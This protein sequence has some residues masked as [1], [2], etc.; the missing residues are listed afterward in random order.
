M[1][2]SESFKK[3]IEAKLQMMAAADPL[4]ATS[5]Q[6]EGKTLDGCIN[7]ILTTVQKSGCAGFADDEIFGMAAHY[8]D[9]DKIEVGKPVNCNVVV[10]HVVELTE[11]EKAAAKKEAFERIISQERERIMKK[12]AP[13]PL[14]LAPAP[15]QQPTLF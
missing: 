1:K 7:Y 10:N 4:F 13:K 9:E 3:T 11:E 14:T 2:G 5:L 15:I 8:Y 12:A 6:K